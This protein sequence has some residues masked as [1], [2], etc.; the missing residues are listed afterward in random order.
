M[1]RRLQE[2]E[3]FGSFES[4]RLL[5]RALRYVAPF[6]GR[7]ALKLGLLCLSLLPLL[8][9]PWPVKIII[10]HFILGLPIGDQPLAYP[11]VVRVF[12]DLLAGRTPLE[13][14]LWTVA[15]Q[16]LL[17]F[18]VGAVGTGGAER[19]QAEGYLASGHDQATQTENEAN[20]GFSMASGLL[21]LLDF[22]FTI[23][24]T[25]AL[26]H[27]YR[28]SL[29]D[30]IQ[31]LPMTSFDDE[32][33]GDAIFRV[34]YDTPAIT[35]GVY[36]I[37]LTPLASTAFSVLVILVLSSVFGNHP[38]IVWT[39]V[40]IL[41]I[42]F[43]ATAP[44]SGALRRRAGRS[45]RAG[46]TTTS[47]L[48]EGLSNILAVQSLGGEG[49]EKRRFDAD[50][51]AS[52]SRHRSQMALGMIITLCAVV[53]AVIVGSRVFYYVANLVIEGT[54]SPGDF[55][56]LFSY[57]MMLTF[58]CVEIGALW[59]RVQ[60]AAV[61]LQ[62]VFFLMDLP[63]ECDPDD[64]FAVDP[65][66]EAV[67]IEDASFSYPDG[68]PALRGVS[69][70]A[71]VGQVTALVGPA[72]AGKT[73]LAYLIPRFIRPAL[74]RVRFDGVDI[75]KASLE[76]VRSQISFV[77]QET[78]LFD[79]T[80]EENIKLGN[81]EASETEVRRAAQVA[82][83]DEFI[84]QLP[85]GYRTQLGRSGGKLSVGQKQRLSIARALVRRSRIVILDEPSSALD[86]ETEQRLVSAL[87]EAS[88]SRLVMVIAHRL[89]MVRSADQILFVEGGRILER[90]SH[91]E[92]MAKPG[93]AYRRFVELQTR[94][95]A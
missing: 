51:W 82:G 31:S 65:L 76:S 67:G 26:N 15:A 19:D 95:A 44:F 23:R 47:T 10:D 81:P 87:R 75:E 16:M 18:L 20:A 11:A 34:M 32:R 79:A 29:F 72:G 24:L 58:A 37:L 74:G 43:A 69:M 22:R 59:I 66:A 25:Q 90:G 42:A 28:S 94:G 54:I 63:A 89:S 86:P 92:L 53:P 9:L 40:A 38:I 4:I 57:F 5:V 21:G 46:A 8:V 41:G 2:A 45:R 35:S 77:F 60:E 71:R 85:E 36:R 49:R 64:S 3:E 52:F 14:L 93:G 39:A 27:H 68:T 33:I 62:R 17:V 78:I 91:T 61:G 55:G 73:T 13:I 12:T 80:I 1:T 7:F 83:A 48:E 30:R 84:R 6:K 70:E 50:S 88:R 56:L